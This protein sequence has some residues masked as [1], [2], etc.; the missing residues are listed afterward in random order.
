LSNSTNRNHLYDY[1]SELRYENSTSANIFSRDCH[2]WVEC[3]FI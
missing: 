2:K 1:N 3:V